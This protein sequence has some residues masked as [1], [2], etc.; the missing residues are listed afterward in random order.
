MEGHRETSAARRTDFLRTLPPTPSTSMKNLA[1]GMLTADLSASLRCVCHPSPIHLLLEDTLMPILL[2]VGVD[3][4]KD[5]LVVACAENH[6]P[7]HNVPNQ[8]GPLLAWLKSLPSG[9]RI[10][11]ESTGHYHELLA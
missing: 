3:V 9:S 2:N 6:F 5:T 1:A 8:R 4:G 10:G 11:L 7:V